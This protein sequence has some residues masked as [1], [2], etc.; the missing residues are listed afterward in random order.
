MSVKVVAI[1]MIMIM[2]WRYG[3]VDAD[4]H[5]DGMMPDPKDCT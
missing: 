4:G 3:C 5:N 2:M 1:V